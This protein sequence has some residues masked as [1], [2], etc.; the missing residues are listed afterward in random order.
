MPEILTNYW[1]AFLIG[2]VGLLAIA[3]VVILVLR[4]KLKIAKK[5]NPARRVSETFVKD[6]VRYTK[7]KDILTEC[8]NVNVTH[9]KG[10]FT[11]E[12]GKDYTVSSKGA[13][14]PG[15]YTVLAAD[16]NAT[17]FNIR[18]GGF[19]RS[20]AHSSSVVLAEGDKIQATSHNVVLR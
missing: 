8:G 1:W 2:L 9:N 15:K 3:F 11:L 17:A 18:V 12:R 7:D 16:G 14:L 4:K 6:G 13:L 19:V 5:G 10:D 20:F